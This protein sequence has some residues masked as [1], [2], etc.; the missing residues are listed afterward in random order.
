[1]A[2]PPNLPVLALALL[3][4]TIGQHAL[5]HAS[6][7]NVTFLG[8]GVPLT[9]PIRFGSANL[10]RTAN[11]T[12]LVDCGAGATQRMAAIGV[13]GQMIDAVFLTH[14]HHDHIIDLI[15][16]LLDGAFGGRA[17]P[18]RVF[19]PAGT[20]RHVEQVLELW[21]HDLER[22]RDNLKAG[23]AGFDF[24]VTEIEPG[25]VASFNGLEVEAVEVRHVIIE[26]AYGYVLR[27]E[28]RSVAFS[29]DTIPVDSLIEAAK[30]VDLLVHS[31]IVRD[32]VANNPRFT[33]GSNILRFHTP[34]TE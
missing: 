30:D 25:K 27:G 31:V 9:S 34:S 28:G 16:L 22:F 11:A 26:R 32:L 10:V 3:L 6:A 20:R 12:V 13:N 21:D 1:M 29:G 14:L 18:Q 24:E 2:Y 5:Q 8:T 23:S 19:G 15:D 33:N 17:V 4:L 7:L